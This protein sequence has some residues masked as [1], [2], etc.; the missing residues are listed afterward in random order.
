MSNDRKEISSFS[1]QKQKEQILID[2]K[3][4]VVKVN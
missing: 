3:I 2:L 4:C 1:E